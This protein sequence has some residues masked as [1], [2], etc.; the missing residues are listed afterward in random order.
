MKESSIS[1]DDIF[2]MKPSLINPKEGQ[3]I[4][5]KAFFLEFTKEVL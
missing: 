5:V 2:N 3:K 4:K 1:N